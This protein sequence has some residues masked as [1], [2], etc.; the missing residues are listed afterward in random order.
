MRETILDHA[1]LALRGD[2]RAAEQR[3]KPLDRLALEVA[4]QS[5]GARFEIAAG[6]AR[7][8]ADLAAQAL[9]LAED[10]FEAR[11]TFA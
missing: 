9:D 11:L 7:P 3:L 5:L 4:E 1:G 2:M 6:C 10:R 8:A